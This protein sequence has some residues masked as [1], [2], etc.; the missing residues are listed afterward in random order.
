MPNAVAVAPDG[1][2]TAAILRLDGLD[3]AAADRLSFSGPDVDTEP[4]SSLSPDKSERLLDV[5]WS[6]TG[7]AVL[8]LSQRSIGSGKRFRLRFVSTAGQVRDLAE[9]PA[10]PVAASWVWARDGHAV[11]FLV[12]S[13]AVALVTLVL[14]TGEIRYL[15][16]LRGDSLPSSGALAPATWQANGWLLYAAPRSTTASGSSSGRASPVLLGVAPGRTDA[17]RIG[18]IEPVFAPMVRDDGLMLTLARADN[19]TL[20]LRPVDPN[21]HVLAEQ[22]L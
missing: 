12:R 2:H 1:L 17:R 3:G 9:F 22:R 10:Q 4:L 15:D 7:T 8:L 6:P 14:G 19:D 21:G 5:S 16:D 11:A 18:D 13:T 20:V